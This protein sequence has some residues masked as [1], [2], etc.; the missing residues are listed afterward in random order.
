M[1]GNVTQLNR[2]SPDWRNE[3][4]Q[5]RTNERIA[6]ALEK[7]ARILDDFAHV[8]LNARFSGKGSDRWSR[9]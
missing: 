4:Q 7:I 8:Y 6:T 3:D 9:R 5:Q 1:M 2:P